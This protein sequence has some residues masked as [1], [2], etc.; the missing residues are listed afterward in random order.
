M[1]PRSTT[2]VHTQMPSMG[3]KHP[4]L[5]AG[6]GEYDKNHAPFDKPHDLGN[7]G[8][9]TKFFDTSTPA[10]V[11]RTTVSGSGIPASNLGSPHASG[12]QPRAREK[13]RVP[14]NNK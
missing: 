3:P 4:S 9:P 10:T 13:A 12:G 7:G 6:P 1:A 5:T 11:G 8:V 14:K 2:P